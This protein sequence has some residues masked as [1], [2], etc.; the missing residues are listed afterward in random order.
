MIN[1]PIWKETDIELQPSELYTHNLA[2]EANIIQVVNRKAANGGNVYLGRQL[3]V[4]ASNYENKAEQGNT[5]AIVRP[6]HLKSVHL[7]T[8]AATPLTVTI[9]EIQTTDLSFVYNASQLL[10]IQGQVEVAEPVQI[11]GTVEVNNADGVP[12]ETIDKTPEKVTFT[13]SGSADNAVVSD[14]QVGEAGKAHY[15]T[16][17]SAGYTAA[18]IGLVTIKDG[19]TVIGEYPIH[20]ADVIQLPTPVKV[21]DGNNVS[22]ELSASGTAGTLGKIFGVGFTK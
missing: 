3:P 10:Q 17:I 20:N 5:G 11:D 7:F 6:Y 2:T 12:L 9:I 1:I 16:T 15:L 8:D 21:T 4:N 18:A 19:L 13:L 14:S 22:I